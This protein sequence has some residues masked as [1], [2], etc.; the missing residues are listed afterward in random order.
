[1]IRTGSE[2]VL[3]NGGQPPAVASPQE[4]IRNASSTIG[5][6]KIF[7]PCHWRLY[8]MLLAGKG[9]EY[10]LRGGR[11]S[12]KSSFISNWCVLDMI[13]DAILYKAGRIQ[14][15][16]LGHCAIFRK[17]G[18]DL[19]DSVFTQILW[20]ID[21]LGVAPWFEINKSNL[22][23]TFKP[24]RQQFQFYG[25]D[26]DLKVKSIK[27]PFGFYKNTWFEELAQFNGM[28]EIRSV[29]QSVQRGG[30]GFRTFCSYNPP[31]TMASWVN[32]EANTPADGRYVFK[33]NYTQVPREW[34]GEEFILDAED[35]KKR[36]E[37]LWLHEY[38]G[39]V[40]GTGGTVFPNIILRHIEDDEIL[41]TEDIRYGLDW[42]YTNAF[43]WNAV[44]YQPKRKRILIFDEIYKSHC[45]I[46]RAI[47][48][49][50]MKAIMDEP[51]YADSADPSSIQLFNNYGITTYAVTK[52]NDSR[53]MGYR[54][55]QG[56]LEIVIDP[57][58]CPNTAREFQMME[59]KKNGDGVF[60]EDYPKEADHNIDAVR[61]ALMD[62]ILQMSMLYG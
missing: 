33:S 46:D 44:A 16:D 47:E 41:T 10:W 58:R 7:A 3:F 1:M 17:I 22:R 54:W 49:V 21:Q 60:I 35:L 40:T 45:T 19:R 20:S 42:G 52:S 57:E 24:T 28:A 53:R 29:K 23:I 18:S 9:R 37:K 39:E 6:K 11:G 61:Y 62:I 48:L 12:A 25:L 27:A 4:A 30:H 38:M 32:V 36:N 59:F 56:L 14:K 43:A 34:L 26:D 2:I 5:I 50:K 51:I 15:S 31:M 13:R 55:L 8:N